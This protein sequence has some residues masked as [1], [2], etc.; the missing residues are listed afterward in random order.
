M[1]KIHASVRLRPTRI[2]FLVRPN[3]RASVRRIMRFCACLWG[4]MFNPIIPVART[5]PQAWRSERGGPR[6][7]GDVA[8]GYLRFFEPDVFVEATKGLAAELGLKEEARYLQH[9]LVELDDFINQHN[10]SPG[11]PTFGLNVF[12]L[13]RHLYEREF[14]FVSRH[15][16]PMAFFETSARSSDN[17]FTEA[18]FGMFPAEDGLQYIQQGYLDA[19]DPLRLRVGPEAWIRAVTSRM[20]TPLR[21]GRR[22]I[23][24]EPDR[25]R[26]PVIFVLDP[27]STMDLI[28]LWNVRQFK[29]RVLPVHV[30]WFSCVQS[31]LTQLIEST[32]RPIRGNPFGT[33]HRTVL[34]FARSISSDEAIA[35]C[36][37]NFAD[38]PKGS[39]FLQCGY[40]N[41][42]SSPDH[43]SFASGRCRRIQL[44]AG[45]KRFEYFVSDDDDAMNVNTI[46][47]EFADRFRG[48]HARWANVLN[49][50]IYASDLRLAMAFPSNIK[51][52]TFPRRLR[53]GGSALIS[54]EGIVLLQGYTRDVERLSL[55]RGSDA[56]LEWLELRGIDAALS[57]AG[58]T[59]EEVVG[60]LGW[61]HG[62][63]L[64][65]AETLKLLDKMA[66]SVRG[67]AP[68]AEWKALIHRR[69]S[70]RRLPKISLD[71]F[72]EVGIL[73]LGLGA[74]CPHCANDNWYSLRELDYRISCARCRRKFDFPQGSIDPKHP[75]WFYRVIGP[76]SVRN[77]AEGAYTTALT[78]RVFAHKLSGASD[79]AM[80]CT[81]GLELTSIHKLEV[82]FAFW[83]RIEEIRAEY[84]EPSLVLGEAK[85]LAKQAFGPIEVEKAA[86]LGALFPG[87]FLVLSTLKESLSPAE[88]KAIGRLAIQGR[89]WLKDGR[90]RS[91]IVVLTATE[92]LA[93]GDVDDAWKK[94]GGM[95]ARLVAHPSVRLDNLWTLM[96]C[97]QQIYLDLPP[98]EAGLAARIRRKPRRRT[99]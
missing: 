11:Q 32:F 91:P 34:E 21:I 84:N 33:M 5:L 78:L 64:E 74:R 27:A 4:G 46:H 99:D 48:R 98:Y 41:I 65:D 17:A 10:H 90:L 86:V 42:W 15:E 39:F 1:T 94:K 97:T 23:E 18:C 95:H 24:I 55:M 47:P 79:A 63:L 26:D 43:N 51:D 12:D 81:T 8:D 52:P 71:R 13:Y 9:R 40:D 7:G 45:L 50:K 85:S 87:A 88:K 93:H 70:S 49:M 82:D 58:R 37:D 80:T 44:N 76:F 3:D 56:F 20:E 61:T 66:S 28:D 57:S 38:A 16:Q 67:T 54:R 96:D 60:S 22:Y 30:G 36:E 53:F 75:P 14:R 89:R 83:F 2:G 62:W 77:F 35:I 31:T 92:L 73:Q 68:V 25:W 19:F 72:T 29:P 6:T 69:A 59:A